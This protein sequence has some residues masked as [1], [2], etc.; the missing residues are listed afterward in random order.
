MKSEAI[1]ALAAALKRGEL[2]EA[3]PWDIAA[4]LTLI[5]E[6]A[7]TGETK[8]HEARKA[9]SVLN[10]YRHYDHTRLLGQV[11]K[12]QRG[13]DATVA[14][15]HAQALINLSA[16]DSA[17]ELLKWALQEAEGQA[18][19]AQTAG[20]ILEYTGL[21]S[22]LEKQRFVIDGDRDTLVRA[23]N[24][25]HEQ[26]E[27]HGSTAYWHGIN[28]VALRAREEREGVERRD[29]PESR[30][31]AAV[32]RDQVAQTY[33]TAPAD[34][35]LAATASEA[36]LALEDCEQ[37][38]LWLY[39]FLHHPKVSPFDIDSYERQLREI[40]GAGA[41]SGG[42]ACAITLAA[43]L[44]RHIARTQAK[45]TFTPSAA[46]AL[47]E[48]IRSDPHAFEKNFLGEGTFS[49]ETVRRMLASCGS[50]GCVTNVEGERLGTGFLV[51]GSWLK[52]S[53]GNGPV[54][55]TN[56]HVIS[57]TVPAAIPLQ[58]A[59]VTF[60]VE[61]AAAGKTLYYRA[62]ELLFTS[63]PG[64]IGVRSPT[65]DDLD[66]TITR[67]EPVE[68]GTGDAAGRFEAL[69]TAAGLPAVRARTKVFVV[70]HPRGSGLQIALHDSVLLDIDE[71]KRL[72]HYRTPTDPGSS[73]SP[74]FNVAWQVIGLHHAGSSATPRLRGTGAYEANEAISLTAIQRKLNA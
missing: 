28:V 27:S 24:R 21:L 32:I 22:R 35:W 71:D 43:I 48:A 66:V 13:F 30:V 16:L 74:V 61:S 8:V 62:G 44:S 72:L 14:K 65:N 45:W 63:P 37:A 25:Y 58:K 38:E 46:P 39:R 29:V 26:Y 52:P 49:V 20:E 2:G 31:L 60:E 73:G 19:G 41:E 12:E 40:W 15:H 34:H 3:Q 51:E 10:R 17:E 23:T 69:E 68:N 4:A 47:R 1:G 56:A 55:V 36:S 70:G 64:D 7:S 6:G 5:T 42:D 50:I 18:G 9:A 33:R 53:F 11:W 54:F 59:R 67:L 57:D